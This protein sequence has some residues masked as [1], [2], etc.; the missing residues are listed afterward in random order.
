MSFDTGPLPS[1]PIKRFFSK[2]KQKQL[3][4]VEGI[5]KFV[6][7]NPK[8]RTSDC[9]VE[10][11][12]PDQQADRSYDEANL[13]HRASS[14]V[15]LYNITHANQK[16][17]LNVAASVNMRSPSSSPRQSPIISQRFFTRRGSAT[18]KATTAKENQDV[19]FKEEDKPTMILTW[20]KDKYIVAAGTIEKLVEQLT[21]ED[22][23]DVGYVKAFLLGY[24][25]FAKPEAVLQM[26]LSRYL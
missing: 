15:D 12:M 21:C 16:A 7:S 14:A 19:V 24:R 10:F 6:T 3:Q 11:L 8:L 1:K 17:L 13:E 22:S 25:H 5:L 2:D 20:R 4:K 23:A 26:L 9:V 18:P